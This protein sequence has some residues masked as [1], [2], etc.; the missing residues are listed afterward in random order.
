MGDPQLPLLGRDWAQLWRSIVG[1]GTP[2]WLN[3]IPYLGLDVTLTNWVDISPADAEA[4]NQLAGTVL[5]NT[6]ILAEGI[7]EILAS[8]WAST[9]SAAR[10][11]VQLQLA[12]QNVT[13]RISSTV[14][15]KTIG[16]TRQWPLMRVYLQPNW[17]VRI[18]QIDATGVGE[19]IGAILALRQL[20]AA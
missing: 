12:D 10:V 15:T 8:C 13:P 1:A 6:G 2:Q 11:R 5:V 18:V 4:T 19:T 20:L 3:S 7:Y 14:L 17:R 16:D 9:T